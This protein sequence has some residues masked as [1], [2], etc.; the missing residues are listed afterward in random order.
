MQIKPTTGQG[1]ING[2]E[3]NIEDAQSAYDYIQPGS[4]KIGAEDISVWGK[5][6]KIR[7]T[8]RSTGKQIDLNIDFKVDHDTTQAQIEDPSGANG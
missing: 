6:F 4:V 5:K 3:M 1:V 8:S 7:L 2:G